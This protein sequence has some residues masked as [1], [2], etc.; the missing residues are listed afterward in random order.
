MTTENQEVN[1]E[2]TFNGTSE[3]TFFFREKKEKGVV[4]EPKRDP[5]KVVLP[6]E[7]GNSLCDAIMSELSNDDAGNIVVSER[8]GKL[9]DFLARKVNEEVYSDAQ[10]Q[11]NA[12]LASFPDSASRIAY[13]LQ[14]TDVDTTKLDIWTLAYKEPPKRGAGAQFSEE[15]IKEVSANFVAFGEANFKTRNGEAVSKQGMLGSATEI[16]INRFKNTKSA[17]PTLE[18]FKTRLTVWFTALTEEQQ[19]A[20]SGL[21]QHLMEKIENYLNPSTESLIGKFE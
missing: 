14:P 4:I 19:T 11:I 5:F 8:G 20:Y 16:F 13:V 17:K 3:E 9:L 12:K 1:Q 7:N 10:A 21:T 18:M 6:S 2:A 15:L